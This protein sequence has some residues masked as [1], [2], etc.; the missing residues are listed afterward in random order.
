MIAAESFARSR[1]AGTAL[2]AGAGPWR[3]R[4]GSRPG[5]RQQSPDRLRAAVRHGR[6]LREVVAPRHRLAVGR[7]HDLRLLPSS[8]ILAMT[9]IVGAALSRGERRL[10]LADAAGVPALY[11]GSTAQIRREI[12]WSLL[13]A[14]IYGA[15]AGLVAWGWQAHGWTPHLFGRGRLAALVAARLGAR[16]SAAA[17]HLVLL[18]APLDAPPAPVPRR[19]CRPS[20]QPPADRLG[21]DE[22]PPAARR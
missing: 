18:D 19:P 20:C 11:E 14:F 7:A 8:S 16:L 21:G 6:A 12:G 4:R 17:R 13:S 15:P 22:L 1:P 10:R 9:A 3:A 5:R 2:P